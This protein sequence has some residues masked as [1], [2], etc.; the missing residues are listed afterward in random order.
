M[1]VTCKFFEILRQPGMAVGL[2]TYAIKFIAGTWVMVG[3]ANPKTIPVEYRLSNAPVYPAPDLVLNLAGTGDPRFNRQWPIGLRFD[4]FLLSYEGMQA[5]LCSGV[6]NNA[7]HQQLKFLGSETDLQTVIVILQAMSYI[8]A[9]VY[10]RIKQLKVSPIEGIGFAGSLLFLVHVFVQYGFGSE[11]KKALLIYLTPRQEATIQDF[12]NR[13][14]QS[15]W[16]GGSDP[17]CRALILTSVVGLVVMVVATWLL[18]PVLATKNK[19]D[20]LGHILFFG[21]FVLQVIFFFV[22]FRQVFVTRLHPTILV[23]PLLITAIMALAGVALAIYATI[24]HWHDEKFAIP[25]PLLGRY[26]PFIG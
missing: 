18:Y 11:S 10:R 2:P 3:V 5:L 20:M 19:V 7:D 9:L 23:T 15:Q 8:T 26:V 6:L 16:A 24:R 1:F 12:W 17:D 25:T 22:Y 4:V 13:N 14:K 21:D